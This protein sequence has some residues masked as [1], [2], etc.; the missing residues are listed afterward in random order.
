[1]SFLESFQPTIIIF[2]W[3]YLAVVIIFF[4]LFLVNLYHLLRFGFF[5][6][7]NLGVIFGSIIIAFA[8]IA[9][10]FFVLRDIDWDIPL[11]NSNIFGS[12]LSGLLKSL[13]LFNFKI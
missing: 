8:L 3:F 12:F 2:Y 9:F 6:F 7:I 5:N 1:M 13:E 10:S 4:L 11:V